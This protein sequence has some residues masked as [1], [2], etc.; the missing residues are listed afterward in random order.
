MKFRHLKYKIHKL[1]LFFLF[2]VLEKCHDVRDRY[3][4]GF[5]VQ[6]LLERVGTGCSVLREGYVRKG[7]LGLTCLIFGSWLKEFYENP[8]FYLRRSDLSPVP[9]IPFAVEVT[10]KASVSDNYGDRPVLGTSPVTEVLVS[11]RIP[12]VLWG[13]SPRPCR[14]QL[15]PASTF[16]EKNLV[17]PWILRS[18]VHV[19]FHFALLPEVAVSFL[20]SKT[21]R[22]S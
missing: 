9:V 3:G 12:P 15:V 5:S 11:E 21:L 6:V 14:R 1:I 8:K 4:S 17:S 16:R 10:L 2:V 18:V 13:V 20:E 7:R 22:G 19:S